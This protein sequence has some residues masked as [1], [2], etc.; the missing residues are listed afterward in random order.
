MLP[1][2]PIVFGSA[3]SEHRFTPIALS[4]GVALSFAAIGL[5]VATI[6]FAIGLTNEVFRMASAVLLIGIGTLLFVPRL[7][8][9]VA[10]AGGT[11]SNGV[12]GQFGGFATHGIGGPRF[13]ISAISE[14]PHEARCDRACHRPCAMF[15]Q[16]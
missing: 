12:E 15:L 10:A 13:E 2:L 7:I 5:F 11:V 6:G 4:A 1:L 14:A 3:A 8:T 9:E 16:T